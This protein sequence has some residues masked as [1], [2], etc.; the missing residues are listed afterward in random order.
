MQEG[1]ELLP[2]VGAFAFSGHKKSQLGGWPFSGRNYS[3]VILQF[4]DRVVKEY[5]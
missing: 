3:P 4:F 1:P 2:T 5:A